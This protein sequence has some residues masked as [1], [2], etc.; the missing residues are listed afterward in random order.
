MVDGSGHGPLAQTAANTAVQAFRKGLE[1]NVTRLVEDIHRA[2]SPTRGAALAVAQ[3]DSAQKVVRYVGVG[4]ISAATL[5]D[6]EVRRMVS[7]NGT[8]GHLAPRIREFTYPYRPGMAV[9]MHSD[10]LSSR[11]DLAHYPGLAA[12]HPSLVAGVLYRDHRRGRD[13]ASI[14]VMRA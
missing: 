3:I 7:H 12:S 6:A 5:V 4:N 10:G 11:W 1:E 8:A 13:D 9:L 14:V 2:L